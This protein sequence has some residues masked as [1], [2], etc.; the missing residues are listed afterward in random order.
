MGQTVEPYD[1]RQSQDYSCVPAACATALN[2]LGLPST[3][4]QMAEL[5]QTRPGTGATLIRALD[6]LDRRLMGTGWRA[7]LLEP[8]VGELERLPLPALTPL[9]FEASRQHMVV[10]SRFAY[11]GV[12]VMDP[13]DGYTYFSR[14]EFEAA[15]RRRV[16]VFERH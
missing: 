14:E 3:E 7:V 4:M 5:T 12:W 15:Y 10:V 1:I 13:M 16:I 6:G 9:Q 2:L 11:D 8:S